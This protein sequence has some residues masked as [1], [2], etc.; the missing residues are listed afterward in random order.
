MSDVGAARAQDAAGSPLP[1]GLEGQLDVG[2]L[3][4]HARAYF[5]IHNI[6]HVIQASVSKAWK[7]LLQAE[8]VSTAPLVCQPDAVVA[9]FPTVLIF[10]ATGVNRAAFHGVAPARAT[11]DIV[12]ANL[13]GVQDC[14]TTFVSTV[15]DRQRA[16]VRACAALAVVDAE[17]ARRTASTSSAQRATCEGDLFKEIRVHDGVATTA[18]CEAACLLQLVDVRVRS[19]LTSAGMIVPA[20]LLQVLEPTDGAVVVSGVA[21][22]DREP[23]WADLRLGDII[24]SLRLPKRSGQTHTDS[25]VLRRLVAGR[26]LPCHDVRSVGALL[27]QALGAIHASHAPARAGARRAAVGAAGAADGGDVSSEDCSD[28]TGALGRGIHGDDDSDDGDGGAAAA[29]N[30]DDDG[31]GSAAPVAV[32]SGSSGAGDAACVVLTVLRLKGVRD[33]PGAA[34]GGQRSSRS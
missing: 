13:Y 32:V 12:E 7:L 9:E 28:D 34:R 22:C 1:L 4:P 24:V 15:S 20:G 27:L 3:P 26:R 30:S 10:D 19:A 6:G 17:V 31:S 25:R 5:A 14:T 33:I 8:S 21:L 2:D 29:G 18:M 16:I 11:E 23:G